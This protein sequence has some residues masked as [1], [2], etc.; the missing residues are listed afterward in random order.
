MRSSVRPSIPDLNVRD[1]CR[2]TSIAVYFGHMP[3]PGNEGPI[4]EGSGTTKR[5]N[6]SIGNGDR[7]DSWKEI[8]GYLGRSVRTVQRWEAERGLPVHR[9]P[10]GEAASVSALKP[11]LDRWLLKPRTSVRAIA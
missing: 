3:Q 9:I 10:G 2:T 5:E 8:A 1:P 6:R 4:F 11:D 7:L